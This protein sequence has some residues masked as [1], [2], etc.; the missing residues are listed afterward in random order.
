MNEALQGKEISDSWKEAAITQIHKEGS[1]DSDVK[2]YRQISLLNTD[3]KIYASILA[4]RLKEYLVEYIGED[5]VSFLPHRHLKDNIRILMNVIEVYDNLPGKKLGLTF[6]D[7][8]KA[9]NN[10]NWEFMIRTLEEW[11]FGIKFINAVKGIYKEQK[12]F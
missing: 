11:N 1:N 6:V 7:A 10:L 2:N 8:E 3:Y 9:F 12:S 4:N 5:Q